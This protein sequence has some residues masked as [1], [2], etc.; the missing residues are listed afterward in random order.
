LTACCD[1]Y[2]V[3]PPATEFVCTV[4]AASALWALDSYSLPRVCEFLQIPLSHHNAQSDAAASANVLLRALAHGYDMAGTAS[5]RVSTWA[6]KH[7]SEEIMTLV[8]SLMED[9]QIDP[10]EIRSAAKWMADNS[11]AAS[12]W[13]GGE[14]KRLL[15]DILRDGTIND[16]EIAGFYDLCRALLGLRERKKSRRAGRK[17]PGVL[18]VCFTGFGPRK[19]A[20]QAAAEAAGYHVAASI[21]KSLDYLVCGP[22][23]GPSKLQQAT[24]RNVRILSSDE[25]Q[26]E[27]ARRGTS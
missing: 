11:D 8:S 4:E 20:L 6:T 10:S 5:G 27:I 7:L 2:G 21:T 16:D 15:D 9:G 3:E 18:A 26:T 17:K 23:P 13:P 14:L 19:A 25:W 1:F 22:S 12:V 24:E